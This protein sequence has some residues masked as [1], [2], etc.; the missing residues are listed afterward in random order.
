MIIYQ[1]IFTC[2]IDELKALL[3]TAFDKGISSFEEWKG[4]PDSCWQNVEQD[5][6]EYVIS[7]ILENYTE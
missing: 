6:D 1:E 3:E 2:S 4:Q 7:F 5:R